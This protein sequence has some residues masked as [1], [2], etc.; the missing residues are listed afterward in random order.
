MAKRFVL[1]EDFPER[2]MFKGDKVYL[3]EAFDHGRAMAETARTGKEHVSVSY[4]EDNRFGFGA[5]EVPKEILS[6]VSSS[7]SDE[8]GDGETDTSSA[9]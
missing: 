1:T 7:E 2:F 4:H 3:S 5:F 6:E 9:E 8:G